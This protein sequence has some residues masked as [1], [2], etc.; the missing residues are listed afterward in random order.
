MVHDQT[1]RNSFWNIETYCW[2]RH[3]IILDIVL[4]L[5]RKSYITKFYSKE[6]YKYILKSEKV[7][8]KYLRK[9]YIFLRKYYIA[10]LVLNRNEKVLYFQESNK[11]QNGG[12]YCVY[13]QM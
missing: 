11:V 6:S 2:L 9:Y 5:R 3:F 12:P 10:K 8:Y 13:I 7:L 1:H 4:F